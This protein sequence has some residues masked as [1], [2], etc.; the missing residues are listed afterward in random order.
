MTN[1][2]STVEICQDH[3]ESTHVEQRLWTGNKSLV[4]G[5]VIRE[6]NKKGLAYYFILATTKTPS[7]VVHGM[8]LL[9]HGIS[10]VCI[11]N[12]QRSED[13]VRRALT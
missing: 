7:I 12:Q 3:Q 6:Q 9:L 8:A 13:E 1:A 10:F 5:V 4:L 11:R 2:L